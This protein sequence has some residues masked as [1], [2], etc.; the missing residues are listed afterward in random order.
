MIKGFMMAAAIVVTLAATSASATP[1][2]GEIN[3]GA[4]PGAGV[5]ATGGSAWATATGIDFKD[6][7]VGPYS[8]FA[9]AVTSATGDL[10]ALETLGVDFY[11]FSFAPFPAGGVTPLWTIGAAGFNLLAIEPVVQTPT[12]ITIKGTGVFFGFTGFED[13]VGNFEFTSQTAGGTSGRFSFS[14]TQV[15]QPV[16]EPTSM[17]LLGLGLMGVARAAARRRR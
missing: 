17:M 6:A 15:S 9:G 2:V 14:I 5:D 13:T 7:L 3:I 10:A 16:P 11:D 8:G 12:S 4:A 1:I